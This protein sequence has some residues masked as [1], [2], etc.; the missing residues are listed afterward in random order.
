[1]LNL[2]EV[3]QAKGVKLRR[4]CSPLVNVPGI[5]QIFLVYALSSLSDKTQGPNLVLNRFY[6][7]I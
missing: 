6:C 3:I 5:D 7:I 1:M 2:S 4:F